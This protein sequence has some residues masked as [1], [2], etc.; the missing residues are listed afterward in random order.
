MHILPTLLSRKT[1]VEQPQYFR[2]VEL[3][4][5]EIEIFLVVFLHLEQVVQLQ[6]QFQEAAASS[7]I[8]RLLLASSVREGFNQTDY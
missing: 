2:N 8:D 6:I 1:S 3:D 4:V 5:F 7:W